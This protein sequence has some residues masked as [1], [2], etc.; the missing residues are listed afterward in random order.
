MWGQEAWGLQKRGSPP[1]SRGPDCPP[2]CLV[3]PPLTLSRDNGSLG[4]Q[5]NPGEGGEREGRDAPRVPRWCS[6]RLLLGGGAWGAWPDH[7]SLPQIPETAGAS[8]LSRPKVPGA[9][10][11]LYRSLWEVVLEEASW[12]R[13]GGSGMGDCPRQWARHCYKHC[14]CLQSDSPGPCL[15]EAPP[16]QAAG[17]VVWTGQ[18]HGVPRGQ[19]FSSC[20]WPLSCWWMPFAELELLMAWDLSGQLLMASMSF[21]T[22]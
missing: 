13:R 9:R 20:L 3:G 6:G 18:L 22:C 2:W 21:S 15:E 19:C 8:R 1:G 4:C 11:G 5:G 16:G 7:L 10:P 12:S 14:S 17:A